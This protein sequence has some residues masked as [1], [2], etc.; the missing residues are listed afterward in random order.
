MYT[1]P[2][3]VRNPLLRER[4]RKEGRAGAYVRTPRSTTRDAPRTT[5]GGVELRKLEWGL[6]AGEGERQSRHTYTIRHSDG[7]SENKVNQVHVRYSV[8]GTALSIYRGGCAAK[9]G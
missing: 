7:I 6:G 3:A 1:P 2:A 8:M 4:N 9:C 5:R